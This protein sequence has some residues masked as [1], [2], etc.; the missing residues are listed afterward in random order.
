MSCQCHYCL[1]PEVPQ[2]QCCGEL[3]PSLLYMSH[4]PDSDRWG[5]ELCAEC[6]EQSEEQPGPG[7]KLLMEIEPVQYV[8][9][10]EFTSWAQLL[11][12]KPV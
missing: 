4:A 11:S 5:A 1:H 12:F 9:D 3:N 6:Y 7:E 2:C 8:G 10:R